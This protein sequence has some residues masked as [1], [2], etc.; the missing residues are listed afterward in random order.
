MGRAHSADI[1]VQ[2][3]PGSLGRD[4]HASVICVPGGTFGDL[5]PVCTA[6]E[7][8]DEHV[9]TREA[10]YPPPPLALTRAC[11]NTETPCF[12]TFGPFFEPLFLRF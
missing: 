7:E 9:A 5:L 10:P 3:T 1:E 8:L 2:R 11:P 12:R 6:R 4:L